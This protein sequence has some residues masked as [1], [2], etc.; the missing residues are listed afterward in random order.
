M[1]KL[2]VHIIR[3]VD[4]SDHDFNNL[5]DFIKYLQ[6]LDKTNIKFIL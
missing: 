1:S 4:F 5:V 6:K 3:A 2:K